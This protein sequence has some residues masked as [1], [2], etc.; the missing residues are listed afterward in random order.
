[1]TGVKVSV[2]GVSGRLKEIYSNSK[3]TFAKPNPITSLA[4]GKIHFW[5]TGT[6]GRDLVL[7]LT[8]WD[9]QPLAGDTVRLVLSPSVATPID[10]ILA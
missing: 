4:S 7:F 5:V 8:I 9:T 2:F 3:C 6:P 1:V 10:N